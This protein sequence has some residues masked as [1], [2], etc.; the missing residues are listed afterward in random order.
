MD[1]ETGTIVELGILTNEC[2]A[3]QWEQIRVNEQSRDSNFVIDE[4]DSVAD[5]E[6]KE[7]EEVEV[8]EDVDDET[9]TNPVIEDDDAGDSSNDSSSGAD[10]TTTPSGEPEVTEQIDDSTEGGQ[11]ESSNPSADPDPTVDT[12]PENEETSPSEVADTDDESDDNR[13]IFDPDGNKVTLELESDQEIDVDGKVEE[14]GS[15]ASDDANAELGGPTVKIIL[16]VS[17]IMI[18][19]TIIILCI[20]CSFKLCLTSTSEDI[21]G[22]SKAEEKAYKRSRSDPSFS[23]ADSLAIKRDAIKEESAVQQRER[24][25]RIGL[26]DS[27]P[28]EVEAYHEIEQASPESHPHLRRGRSQR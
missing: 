4:E 7:E 23:R 1:K 28:A 15:S 26:G 3:E 11:D 2:T 17:A 22:M 16:A 9:D 5:D 14:E 12:D 25:R 18:C 19:F 8:I 6:D 13:S 24:A 21:K 20:Y 10:D 27:N